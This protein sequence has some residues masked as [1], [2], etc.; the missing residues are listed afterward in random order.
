MKYY[1][2]IISFL[3]QSGKNVFKIL[4]ESYWTALTFSSNVVYPLFVNT[5][6][7]SKNET[8]FVNQ[9]AQIVIFIEHLKNNIKQTLSMF[10]YKHT[11]EIVMTLYAA[12][13]Y[14]Y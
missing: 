4:C 14:I 7:N 1:R 9:T 5:S 8:A 2:Y 13:I 3:S 10:I 6:Q 11:D 12:F